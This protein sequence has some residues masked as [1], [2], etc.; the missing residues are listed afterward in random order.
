MSKKLF[1]I[2][3]IILATCAVVAGINSV[4][5][6]QAPTLVSSEVEPAF[7]NARRTPVD[8]QIQKAEAIIKRAPERAEGYN[9]LAAAYLQKA[10]ETGDFGFNSRAESALKR[11]LEIAPDDFDALKLQATLLLAFHRFQEALEVARRAQIA[12]PD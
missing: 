8:S 12:R 4:W 5:K 11:S 9:L 10:R 2:A 6:R 1:I 3:V 7:S